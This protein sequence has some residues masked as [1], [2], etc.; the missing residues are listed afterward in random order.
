MLDNR[1]IGVFDSGLGG[2]T[3]VKRLI[4]LL[5]NEK[6]IYLGDTGRVPYGG[7]S[8]ETLLKYTREDV[9]F[10]G[11]F[12]VKVIVVACNTVSAV[13]LDE[14]ENEYDIPMI[15]VIDAAVEKALAVTKNEK[16][17]VI[18]TSATIKSGIY[19]RKIGAAGTGCSVCAAAC[20]LLVPLVESGRIQ[21]GDIVIE[22]VLREYLEPIKEFGADTLILGCTHYPLLYDMIADIM[23]RDVELVNS[24]GVTAE[25]V[26]GWL[27][28][29][30]L[31]SSGE[32]GGI[33][34]YVTDDTEGFESTASLFLQSDV[35]GSVT[36]VDL[37]GYGGAD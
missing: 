34:Y 3:A 33:D 31:L 6:I 12:D 15:G 9:A 5:P 36:K 32:R 14:V 23:G 17:G 7:R 24:G 10:L 8:K 13:A 22:T 21:K 29:R 27:G 18:G 26:A 16:I 2:L 30:G 25:Y 28:G 20:P 1:A 19:A 35:R 37:D 4:E 11:R